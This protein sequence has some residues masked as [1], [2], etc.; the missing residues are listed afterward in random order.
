MQPSLGSDHDVSM[1]PIDTVSRIRAIA[2]DGVAAL[3]L[4]IEHG[5]TRSQVRAAVDRGLLHRPRYGVVAISPTSDAE[6]DAHHLER[7]R[8]VL[9]RY[10]NSVVVSHHTAALLHGMPLPFSIPRKVQLTSIN[11]H[12]EEDHDY[13]LHRS[14]HPALPTTVISGFP[15]TTRLRTALDISR[16][17]R[18]ALALVTVEWVLRH[19]TLEHARNMGHQGSDDY[20]VEIPAAVMAAREDLRKETAFFACRSG[21]GH[22][23]ELIEVASPLSESPLESRSRGEFATLGVPVLGQQVRIV[24]AEGVHRR[25]DFLLAPW[26]AGEADGSIKYEGPDGVAALQKEKMR[27]RA[28]REVG[29]ETLRWNGTE[30]HND[31]AS[32][33]ARIHRAL[34]SHSNPI[35]PSNGRS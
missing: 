4:L 1:S 27:D 34:T 14:H 8:A 24:D 19:T 10:D 22:L 30:M 15:V 26:L 29:I 9:K 28:L 18:F 33:C 3:S 5:I 12:H 21:V 23:R 31:P 6:D 11:D 32:V 13:V 2:P 7:T 25:V 17:L 20:L 16:G 35:W